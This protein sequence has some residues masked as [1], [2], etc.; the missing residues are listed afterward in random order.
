MKRQLILFSTAALLTVTLS[1]LTSHAMPPKPPLPGGGGSDSEMPFEDFSMEELSA[2]LEQA[3]TRLNLTDEQKAQ[4]EALALE[5][6]QEIFTPQQLLELSS[7]MGSGS[8]PTAAMGDMELSPET[9]Q[10]MAGIII[11][12]LM[13]VNSILTAEQKAE[14]RTMLREQMEA[15]SLL[16]D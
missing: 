4:F 16:T 7:K 15:A 3:E 10:D 5:T 11:P 14:V 12:K 6:A 8:S 13:Q 9:I 2:M 1:P